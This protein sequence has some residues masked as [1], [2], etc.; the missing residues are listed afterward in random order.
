MAEQVTSLRLSVDSRD[1][2]N[3]TTELNNLSNSSKQ[4][5]TGV[6]NLIGSFKGVATA[7]ASVYALSKSLDAVVGNGFR[8]NKQLEESKAG[9]VALSVA[10]QNTA[11]PITERYANANKEATDTLIELQKINAQ[12]PHT[13]SQTNEIYKAMYVSMKN[14]GAST[15]DMINLT[16]QISI[17]S[18][19][20]GIDFNALLAGVDGLASGTVLANSDLGRFLSSLGLTNEALKNSDDVVKLLTDRLSTF[21]AAD[22]MAVAMSNLSNEW[23]K[24]TGKLTESAFISSKE[25]IKEL[26]GVLSILADNTDKV[27]NVTTNL[28]LT[29]GILYGGT[30]ALT[31]STVA[32]EA[33]LA[34]TSVTTT[35]A[36][37]KQG[38]YGGAIATTETIT[39]R[40]TAAQIAQTVATRGLGIAMKAIPYVAVASAIYTIVD[41]FTEA[42][43]RSEDLEVA[44]NRQKDAIDKLSK[45]EAAYSKVLVQKS[46]IELR[47]K[48]QELLTQR[49]Q[50]RYS[51]G[52][53]RMQDEDYLALKSNLASI[54][55]EIDDKS[56][57]L[58]Q[59]E[60]IVNRKKKVEDE[61]TTKTKTKDKTEDE[62][63]KQE[64]LLDDYFN[65]TASNTEKINKQYDDLFNRLWNDSSTT[66]EMLEKV[67]EA[68]S[69]AL[70]G[71][72]KKQDLPS[73]FSKEQLSDIDLYKQA[74][75]EIASPLDTLNEK[76]QTL[77]DTMVKM[78]DY[79]GASKIAEKWG[80][81][82]DELNKK[83][84]KHFSNS[85]KSFEDLY[86]TGT[87]LMNEFYDEDDKRKKKQQEVD[88]AIRIVT[89]TARLADL[90][91]ALTTETT[92][93]SALATTALV[94][95]LQLTFPANIPAYAAVA[96]MIASL[97][98][99]FSG[100]GGGAS[101]SPTA[102]VEANQ[103]SYSAET[104]LITDRLDR[105]IDLLEKMVG[106]GTAASA[107]IKSA[108]LNYERSAGELSYMVAQDVVTADRTES[109]RKDEL[110]KLITLAGKGLSES[111]GYKED[112]PLGNQY[113]VEL[114][115]RSLE[116]N[117]ADTI[118][119]IAN[120]YK[121]VNE[122]DFSLIDRFD[123][124]DV[125][126]WVNEAEEYIYDYAS[127]MLDV[128][129]T[130]S[131]AKDTFKDIYDDITGTQKYYFEDLRKAQNDVNNLLL[132]SGKS[133]PDYLVSQIEAIRGIEAEFGTN[134]QEL[135]LSQNIEDIPKQADALRQL[136]D[137]TGLAFDNGVED[138]LNYLDSIELVGEAMVTSADNIKTW[139][140]SFKTQ[141]DLVK[142]SMENYG[143][144]A[145][146]LEELQARFNELSTDTEGLTDAELDALQANKDYLA[147]LG[148]IPAVIEDVIASFYGFTNIQ[149]DTMR[150]TD[151][152]SGSTTYL[153]EAMKSLDVS[154][155]PTTV[156]G[157]T[158]LY[159]KFRE[160]GDEI[161][162]FEQS[163]LTAGTTAYKEREA[164]AQRLADERARLAQEAAA[165]AE[166]A[167]RKQ[168]EETTRAIE[169]QLKNTNSFFDSITDFVDSLSEQQDT[170]TLF[171][172][173]TTSFNDMLDAVENGSANLNELGSKAIDTANSY[174]QGVAEN[175]TSARDVAFARAV[176]A[177]K[178]QG[179]A[180]LQEATLDDLLNTTQQ[181]LGSDSDIVKYLS[182]ID[183]NTMTYEDYLT[184]MEQ[185]TVPILRTDNS[186]L[187]KEISALRS[188]MET[189][190]SLNI[191][192]TSTQVK[193][194]STQRAILDSVSA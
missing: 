162:A 96:G 29:A 129:D 125:F 53:K 26:T 126:D 68:R 59:Y 170:S 88:R 16:K 189:L 136:S 77:F 119:Y 12:T 98:I 85:I 152:L 2:K 163:I 174:L 32:Y 51:L 33:I 153:N 76:F 107:Q 27:I 184:N 47:S 93:Q 115:T 113:K 165:A 120:L 97:G 56:E 11:I 180:N 122:I 173:F 144:Y 103:E 186:E 64:K 60:E 36:T 175:A 138:A 146:T 171:G 4:A 112:L 124:Q 181:Y 50:M 62:I 148:K 168:I 72:A 183:R 194:L 127:S 83:D 188:E 69:K 71:T 164:E 132:E 159:E 82:I 145:S 150:F 15:S 187:I 128:V 178:F 106:Q 31:L 166:E 160:S 123:K 158:S 58:K 10:V 34:A 104:N 57:L 80:G 39:K 43:K 30:K 99:A 118:T 193:T 100:G 142:E 190:T 61:A 192:S 21:K 167:R 14:A 81:S 109:Y 44:V 9:L 24:F 110:Y 55:K 66:I 20:A 90:A 140:D 172:N 154:A 28:A 42:K 121:N 191:T 40:M 48:Q 182:S 54:Q 108:Q 19:A 157:L 49:T 91:M 95:Q 151:N 139:N 3:A 135:L 176:V 141:E 116:G 75:N 156:D 86:G 137:A 87:S 18:G 6:K 35:Q 13:L 102:G 133:F 23:D 63:K 79:D 1:V 179:V 17:A 46:L 155:I 149:L 92:K 177:N 130:M 37:V 169:N 134:I 94:A 22:T 185:S 52:E 65:A 41:A 131:D 105:Q 143:G 5:E 8:Y 78:G 73:V 114:D 89:Q 161:D 111:I 67:E 147:S 7:V 74:I 84:D 45:S 38:L 117:V 101:I 70:G 25:S